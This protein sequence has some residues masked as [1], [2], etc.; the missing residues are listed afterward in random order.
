[1]MDD[2]GVSMPIQ[3]ILMVA[4]VA[5][6]ASGLFIGIGGFVE[7]QQEAAIR[8]GM[9]TTGTRLASDLAAADRLAAD[10]DGDSR[11]ELVVDAPS[12]VAGSTYLISLQDGTNNTTTIQLES[13]QPNVVVTVDVVTDLDIDTPTTVDGGRLVITYNA[14]TDSLEV[15]DG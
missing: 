14:S 2:R 13:V 10:F 6:L 1:M 15:R 3:Y 8:H 4:I 7:A 9:D 11:L 12:S 5:I